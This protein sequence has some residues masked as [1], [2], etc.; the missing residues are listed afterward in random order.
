[1]NFSGRQIAGGALIAGGTAA[2][3]WLMAAELVPTAVELSAALGMSVPAPAAWVGLT[4][5]ALAV[6]LGLDRALSRR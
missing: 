1:M 2:Y 5:A 3:L 6:A 4:A